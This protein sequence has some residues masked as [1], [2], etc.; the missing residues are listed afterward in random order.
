[1]WG[2]P[3]IQHSRSKQNIVSR[4]EDDGG[5][6]KALKGEFLL[7][8]H[9]A[10]VAFALQVECNVCSISHVSFCYCFPVS[11]SIDTVQNKSPLLSWIP[12]ELTVLA[13]QA[14]SEL[15]RIQFPELNEKEL[16]NE[17]GLKKLVMELMADVLPELK[18]IMKESCIDYSDDGD[19]ISAASARTP[20][21][22]AIVAAYQFRWFVTQ[23]EYPH[24]GKL[25]SLVIPCALTAVDHWS[26]EVKGQ[27]MLSFI[28]LVKN[29]NAA[30]FGVYEDVILDICCKNIASTDELWHHVV[31]M[32][33]LMVTCT[34]RKNPRSSWF[35]KMMNEMLSHLERQPRHKDRR[36]S[37]LELIEPVFNSMGIVL[38]AHFTRIFPL[39]F[40]WMHA[41]DDRTVILVL[42]MVQTIIKLTWIRNT[43]Y[44]ERL[45]EE[46]TVAHKEAAL[47]RSREEIRNQVLQILVLLQ[48]CKGPQF[49][50][51]WDKYRDD[52]NLRTLSSSLCKE[53][54]AVV[55][56]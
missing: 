9:C 35:E 17:L 54:A 55:A 42:E 1:M 51:V 38:L 44:T 22:Y 3:A 12:K 33:V 11:T 32:S 6:G 20:V 56:H 48:K 31:E 7:C 21:V 8:G 19:E 13:N 39:L 46:L 15:P 18:G 53:T 4:F 14:L 27:G 37:W 40:Q 34:Q 45:V 43:P 30:E 23:V 49:E 2:L 24:L 41:D 47:R 28:H 50:E 52:P 29:V 26:P 16:R 25:C 10:V 5:L 36:N